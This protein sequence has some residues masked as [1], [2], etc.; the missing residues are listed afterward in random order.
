MVTAVRD[1]ARAFG[2]GVKEPA[3]GEGEL[4]EFAV[5][6]IQATQDIAPGDELVVGRN[7]AALRPGSRSRGL[8]A[9]HLRE[10]S[11]RRATRAI[12]AGDGIRRDDYEP[13]PPYD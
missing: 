4:R 12:Q 13:P 7:I 2:S 5:R 1:A 3:D 9:R 6:A 8:D 11:G 10:V